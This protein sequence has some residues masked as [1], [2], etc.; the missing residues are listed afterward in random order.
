MDFF[1][2]FSLKHGYRKRAVHHKR[3]GVHYRRNER[4]GDYGGIEFY[5]FAKSGSI[6]PTNFA[7]ITVSDSE[8]DITEHLESV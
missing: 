7:R 5:L 1:A 8:T 6:E 4:R 2:F 3:N